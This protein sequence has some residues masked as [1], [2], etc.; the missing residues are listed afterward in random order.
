MVSEL[1]KEA[2]DKKVIELSG[3]ILQAWSWGEFQK[4]LGQKILRFSGP[5]FLAQ[6]IETP[7]PLGKNYLYCPRGPLGEVHSALAD[8]KKFDSDRN[9]VFARLEPSVA[10][11]LPKA[12]KEIQPS[13]VWVLS[14]EPE[15]EQILIG[16]KPKTRYNINLAQ[17]K[18]VTVKEGSKENLLDFWKLAIQTAERNKFKLHPQ[19]YYWKMWEHLFPDH[20]RL[21]LAYY[22]GEAVAAMLLTTFSDTAVYLHG[23]STQKYKEA[24]A[25][26]LL[27][28]E[29]I[30]LA[31]KTG[32]K[33][34]DFGGVATVNS[35][36][37]HPWAGITRFKKSFGGFE[38]DYPGSFDLVYSPIW[39]NA[40]KQGRALLRHIR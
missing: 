3:S 23:G 40:Y 32:L 28:W 39:Y 33:F 13:N 22:K 37:N 5:D 11:D 8:F 26:F 7:L 36:E 10:L 38:I 25:P 15:E 18:G 6:A 12:V 29:A 27:H 17:R 16:M 4:S 1:T 31:K 34:Y 20:L 14:L 9:L 19:E 21:L 24:M 35:Q 30:K 2:W